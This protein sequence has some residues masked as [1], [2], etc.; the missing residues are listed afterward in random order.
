M[1]EERL[2]KILA[3]AGFGSRRASE[4]LIVEGR[5]TVNGQK[6][7]LGTKADAQKDEILLDG[8]P[9]PKV[10]EEEVYIALHKPRGVLSDDARDDD[11][12]TVFDMVPSSGHLFVVGRLD[13]DSEGLM[14]LTN[15]GDLANRLTHPRYGH[16]KEYRVLLVNR[17]DEKQLDAWRHGVVLEDGYRTQPAQVK[18]EGP[19]GKGVWMRVIMREGK[20]RQ[21]REIGRT[22][23]LPVQRIIRIRIGALQLGTLK[24]G[25]WRNLTPA[26]VKALK[27]G[28]TITDK[29]I[30]KPAPHPTQKE[31]KARY[32][33]K[34]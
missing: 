24:L 32:Q 25:E 26:E 12:R 34:K 19:A 22:I 23:G 4:V 13:Y 11:R 17:P 6:A 27:G 21:I 7:I 15:N 5:V 30:Q 33:I 18:I 3:R 28:L 9:I 16:E 1:S 14:L 20:K 2:Q 10:V 29:R 31:Y 8:H